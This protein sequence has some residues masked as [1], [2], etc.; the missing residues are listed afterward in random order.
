[1]SCSDQSADPLLFEEHPPS[2]RK[3][4]RWK[5]ASRG[6]K[7]LMTLPIESVDKGSYF[8][9]IGLNI[10][11]LTREGP[12]CTNKKKTRPEKRTVYKDM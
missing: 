7:F 11:E 4:E 12:P 1:M 10:K 8:T 3:E 2:F 5:E 9:D 6:K